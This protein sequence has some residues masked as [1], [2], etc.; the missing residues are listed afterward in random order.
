[1]LRFG[2]RSFLNLSL[3]VY[4]PRSIFAAPKRD[5]N[6]AAQQ[7][8][9]T[10]ITG[11]LLN[12][13]TQNPTGIAPELLQV[14]TTATGDRS[15]KTYLFNEEKALQYSIRVIIEL[16][17]LLKPLALHAQAQLIG[18]PPAAEN[19]AELLRAAD[20]QQV[21]AL[22]Q[23]YYKQL[24]Q[25]Q[26]F[27]DKYLP[28]FCRWT[29][30]IGVTYNYKKVS[31]SNYT[32]YLTFTVWQTN[33][34][35]TLEC[36]IKINNE[37][38]KVTDFERKAFFL[39]DR[40]ELFMLPPADAERL[41]NLL[42]R[43]LTVPI[44]QKQKFLEQ[45]VYPLK[46]FYDVDDSAIAE[47]IELKPEPRPTIRLSELSGDFLVISPGFTYD[48]YETDD[49]WPQEII[50]T[51][52]ENIHYKIHRDLAAEAAF[53][54]RLKAMH[55]DF[56]RQNKEYF[57][58]KTAD[59]LK[60]GWFYNFYNRLMAEGIAVTGAERMKQFKYNTHKAEVTVSAGNK[61]DWFDVLVEVKFGDY[62]VPLAD[63]R[64]ALLNRQQH[65]LL[66]DGSLG[67]LPAG[68]AE[69]YGL[70]LKMGQVE[71]NRL[72]VSKYHWNTL[73]EIDALKADAALQKDF[74]L[75]KNLLDQQH[76]D[77]RYPLP[78]GIKAQLRDYQAAGFQWLC[79][80]KD[81][82]WGACLADDMGLGKTL[83][84]ICFLQ[85]IIHTQP[86]LTHLVV[87]PTSL[88]F[89][90]QEEIKKFA[91]GIS[92]YLHY[93]GDRGA[94]DSKTLKK[95][96]IIITSYGNMRG[97]IE[98]LKTI[99]FGYVVLD[100]SHAIK[101][102]ASLVARAACELQCANRITLS[103]T[104]VQNNTYDL[105][106]Q[107]NFLNPGLL[108]SRDFFKNQFANRIDK[109][110]DAEAGGQLRKM[111]Y[112][113]LLRRTKE[114]VA[115]DLPDRTETVL[116]CEMEAEQR[117][118]YN[119]FK[120]HYR[121]SLLGEIDQNG[122]GKS[123]IQILEGLTRLRQVCN[124][125]AI[126]NDG[127]QYP[128]VSIKKEELVREIEDNISDHKALVF[129]QFTS[130]LKLVAATLDEK[131]IDYLYL[132]GA[133]PA[134]QRQ[135]LVKQFQES[136]DTRI[137]LISLKA[138]GVGL[139]LTAADYVYLIDP[140]WNPAAEAQAIDRTH[141]IGQTQK[142]FA[143]KMIC[144]DTVEEKILQLQAK[145]KNLSDTLV[146]EETGFVKKLTREDIDFLFS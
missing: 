46:E 15:Y 14:R 63:L 62:I 8:K 68:F 40:G 65:V 101:N 136:D 127:K 108:G 25:L 82:Q 45:V 53:R 9:T 48:W 75:K 11:L 47:V 51:E 145:K 94:L 116:W 105:Y 109:Y 122:M 42:Q 52:K 80:M 36:L 20:A 58:L 30:E 29:K 12:F 43:T 6:M 55:P 50:T 1:V 86:G 118:I 107:F 76:L 81:L 33:K 123:S 130:M 85:H 117:K 57:Y 22:H 89:N 35:I 61:I 69:E 70:L 90:W 74:T 84:T 124:S 128:D 66:K 83:Q 113:F 24:R 137:F 121:K 126:I 56:D 49:V 103:G 129:S 143:Y 99:P 73:Q 112:P 71:K 95:H 64:N 138:G 39:K 104:P 146:A 27:F 131:G 54:Q 115:K 26:P 21:L 88:I 120:D 141:R 144:R 16:V 97:D 87:C 106:A 7:N 34:L 100:E 13:T 78:K 4:L 44:K 79:L 140:W 125:P 59:A 98:M 111:V 67:I 41:N 142:V 102:P 119:S 91:P 19:P 92:F 134:T 18:H 139:T 60:K 31:L 38:F 17:P 132:D 77:K 2:R 28:L 135:A 5:A 133:T 3:P 114:Q 93:G 72:K 96:R 23:L 10:E 32:P 110:G 37:Y